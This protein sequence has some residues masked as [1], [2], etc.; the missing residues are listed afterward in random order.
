MTIAILQ[1]IKTQLDEHRKIVC[2]IT[3]EHI[4]LSE[5]I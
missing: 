5:H 2:W 4:I 1:D 3:H